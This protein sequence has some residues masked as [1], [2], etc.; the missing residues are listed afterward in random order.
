MLAVIVLTIT[1]TPSVLAKDKFDKELLNRVFD[2]PSTIMPL[3]PD[4]VNTNIYTKCILNVKKKNFTLVTVPHIYHIAISPKRDFLNESYTNVD[5]IGLKYDVKKATQLSIS[6]VPHH[7]RLIALMKYLTPDIY[8]ETLVEDWFLS[9]LH[10]SNHRLYRYSTKDHG[11]STAIV[12][13]K[14]RRRNTQLVK[15]IAIV[16]KTTGRIISYEI[17]G[18][19]DMVKFVLKVDMGDEGYYALIPNRCNLHAKFKYLGN[20]ILAHFSTISGLSHTLPDSIKGSRDLSLMEQ[21]RPEPLT[22]HEDSILTSFIQEKQQKDSLQAVEGYEKKKKNT[23]EFIFWDI[24]GDNLFNRRKTNFGPDDRGY[25]RIAPIFNPLY[26]GYSHHKGIVY[27]FDIKSSYMLSNNSDIAMRLKIGYSFKQH[28]WYYN[29]PFQ[30]NFNNKRNGYVKVEFGNGNH[31]N[32]SGVLEQVKAEQR[33]S[34]DWNKMD[35]EY[36]KNSF[37]RTELGIDITS[38]IGVMAGLSLYTRTPVNEEGFR[39]AGKPLKYR[40]FSPIIA[41]KAHP[42]WASKPEFCL[43]YEQG[44]KGIFNSDSE[45]GRIEFDATQQFSMR[46]LRS[47]YLRYGGGMYVHNHSGNYFLDYYNF[48]QENIPPGWH[49]D[50][51]GE[52][53]LLDSH[54]YNSSDYYLRLNTTYES[55]LMMLTYVPII[56]QIIEKERLY[57]SLLKVRRLSSYAELGYGFTNRIF[58]FGIFTGFSNTHY[59]GFGFRIGLELFEDW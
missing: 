10:R 20:T 28:Q 3:M 45:Y 53:R 12:S 16:E 50:W 51:K 8:S 42:K 9:P 59:E 52:F 49:D 31:I 36:F 48:R 2:Y 44:V 37:F 43:S 47:L 33:D 14:P 41:L 6:T 35:M 18:E 25:L 57:F 4:T 26:F 29:I 22:L 27:K 39:L 17:K 21:L 13:F 24:L 38:T 40:S 32:D 11:N 7:N 30:W 58:S 5:I 55:P 46:Q 56:G 34:V 15:G 19:Y 54:W 23:A 1:V